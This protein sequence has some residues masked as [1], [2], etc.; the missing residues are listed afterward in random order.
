MGGALVAFMLAG[1]SAAGWILWSGAEASH[2]TAALVPGVLALVATYY[3]WQAVRLLRHLVTPALEEHPVEERCRVLEPSDAPALYRLVNLL[4]QR[5]G[6]PCPDEIRL[7]PEPECFVVEQRRF[8]LYTRRRLVLV[9][10]VP[11]LRVLRLG[12]LQALVAHELAHLPHDT[13]TTVFLF[14]FSEALH[15][16]LALPLWWK[17]RVLDPLWWCGQVALWLLRQCYG[18]LRHA[19][20]FLADWT[21]A[22]LVGAKVAAQT[23]LKEWCV[24]TQFQLLL[25]QETELPQSWTQW[26]RLLERFVRQWEEPGPGALEYLEHRL[27]QEEPRDLAEESHPPVSVRLEFLRR[28]PCQ[29]PD[30]AVQLSLSL[31]AWGLLP[32]GE[33]NK[34]A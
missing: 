30:P 14:R 28:H 29:Q 9:L 17:L 6:R 22:S 27:R 13:T 5:I 2:W 1:W 19:Q 4:A 7:S 34:L 16:D 3:G 21:S 33:Q 31:P 32:V 20:E 25:T 12:E 26:N 8:G 15:R 18:P 10:G 11:H 23:L 24:S